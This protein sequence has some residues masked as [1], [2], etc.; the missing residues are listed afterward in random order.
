MGMSAVQAAELA[1]AYFAIP[2][3]VETTI[4][5]PGALNSQREAEELNEK[6]RGLPDEVKSEIISVFDR[7]GA[8]A[9]ERALNQAARD[10]IATINVRVV[11][12]ASAP[13]M[14]RTTYS[15]HG[16]LYEADGHGGLRESHV[17]QIAPAGAWR[18]WAE[19]ETGGE[20]YIPLANDGRRG[21]AEEIWREVGRRFGLMQRFAYGGMTQSHSTSTVDRSVSENHV[22]LAPGSI[23]IHGLNA[24]HAVEELQRELAGR[25]EQTG[26]RHG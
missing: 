23:Q 20:A 25:F 9:A 8:E 1:D 22:H 14:G 7:S 2:E 16:N 15:A 12:G 17:A 18:V 24:V 19:D 3:S 11:G 13:V 6:L 26:G 21:R 5:T 4:A 10:R